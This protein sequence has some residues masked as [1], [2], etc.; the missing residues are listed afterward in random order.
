MVMRFDGDRVCLVSAVPAT[1]FTVDISRSPQR[2]V[3]TFTSER[4]TAE[5]VG[6]APGNQV[7]VRQEAG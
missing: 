2:L 1:E 4:A 5:V 6:Q 3:V 7:S